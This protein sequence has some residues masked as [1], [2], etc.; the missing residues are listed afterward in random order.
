LKGDGHHASTAVD[1]SEA[2]AMFA[3]ESFDLVITD[4]S[5]PGMNGVQLAAA[6]K[7]LTPGT[8]VILLT[9]FGEE[10]L[11][12]GESPRGVDLVLGKPVTA[13]D[14]RRAVFGVLSAREVRSAA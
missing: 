11:A 6:M 2:L 10:M 3:Q 8:P 9:G 14:L 1:S 5:M 12:L 13:A 7:E 4:Q